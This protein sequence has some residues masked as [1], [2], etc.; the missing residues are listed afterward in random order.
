MEERDS[1]L[2]LSTRAI[3]AGEKIDDTTR[4]LKIP[5]WASNTFSYKDMNLLV[6]W[7]LESQIHNL[8]SLQS[9]FM[10]PVLPLRRFD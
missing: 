5:I 3:H 6:L 2:G 9:E 1:N 7:L 4:A 8:T 10:Q